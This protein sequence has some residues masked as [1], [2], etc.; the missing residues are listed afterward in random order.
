MRF[1]RD[2][3]GYISAGQR[4]FGNVFAL[5]AGGNQPMHSPLPD[6]V[7]TVVALGPEFNQRLLSDNAFFL[8]FI[9]TGLEHS[10][11]RALS[12][13]LLNMNGEKHKQQRRWM[14]PAFQKSRLDRY[15]DTMM[16]LILADLQAWRAGQHRDLAAEMRGLTLRIATKIF[17]GQDIDPQ[18]QGL[19]PTID[20]WVKLNGTPGVYAFPWNLPGLPYRRLLKLSRRLL[21]KLHDLIEAKRRHG[22]DTGDVMD[23]LVHL[24]R[25]DDG[26]AMTPDELIGQANLLFLAGHETTANSLTWTLLLLMQHP[27]VHADLR[28][29]LHGVL[30]GDPPRLEHLNR[31]PLLER[32]IKESMRVLP[33]VPLG[34]RTTAAACEFAGHSLPAHTE[35]IFSQY[36]TH[37]DPAIYTEPQRFDPSRW[38]RREP[39][40]YEYIP[41]GGGARLCLG[42]SFALMEIKAVLAT[43]LQRWAPQLRPG[44]RIDRYVNLTLSPKHGL[45][46]DLHPAG[47]NPGRT[48]PV[49]GNVHEMVDLPKE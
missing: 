30:H 8:Q 5:V 1:A 40:A 3:I 35:I 25:D 7:G 23:V 39:S 31:L 28:D 9:R 41:F 15:F 49:V 13:G 6:S 10:P 45:P 38:E 20:A 43:L 11:Y 42:A 19:G 2:S 32:V 14:M 36:H 46:V 12:A 26:A 27:R 21:A 47:A 24:A 4:R 22:A 29:E 18:A 33:A 44:T 37:H 34:M 16:E 48:I 17:F